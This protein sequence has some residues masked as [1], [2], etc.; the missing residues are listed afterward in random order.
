[1]KKFDRV[2]FIGSNWV[3][4]LQPTKKE[5]KVLENKAIPLGIIFYIDEDFKKT[6]VYYQV[7][8]KI[9]AVQIQGIPRYRAEELINSYP[10]TFVHGYIKSNTIFSDDEVLIDTALL[11]YGLYVAVD[12][13]ED[14]QEDEVELD[15]SDVVVDETEDEQEDILEDYTSGLELCPQIS[16]DKSE[17]YIETTNVCGV[18]IKNC[19]MPFKETMLVHEAVENNLTDFL[20]DL[21]LERWEL[22]D[23]DIDCSLYLDEQYNNM[24][25]GFIVFGVAIRAFAFDDKYLRDYYLG[26]IARSYNLRKCEIKELANLIDIGINLESSV[27]EPHSFTL[28]NCLKSFIGAVHSYIRFE[29]QYDLTY[30]QIL[31]KLTTADCFDKVAKFYLTMVCWGKFK[32]AS[33]IDGNNIDDYDYPFAIEN[34]IIDLELFEEDDMYAIVI[35]IAK[36]FNLDTELIEKYSDG[37]ISK[38]IAL[39][40]LN[41]YY[42]NQNKKFKILSNK[43]QTTLKVI[44]HVIRKIKGVH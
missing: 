9:F 26:Y 36:N 40:I 10:D 13:T 14:E 25:T 2:K 30:E 4:R 18:K 38:D 21:N 19:C 35:N 8:E 42:D 44:A 37:N 39:Y 20:G 32:L 6:T 41:K 11:E 16:E 1:M 31:E 27:I 7:G 24:V 17:D 22:F 28:L 43:E 23:T 33:Y 15:S 3:T 29:I 5:A 34:Y 12:E